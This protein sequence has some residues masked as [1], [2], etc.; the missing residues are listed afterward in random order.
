M[1]CSNRNLFVVDCGMYIFR[2]EVFVFVETLSLLCLRARWGWIFYG[3][4]EKRLSRWRN[5]RFFPKSGFMFW[6]FVRYRMQYF[7]SPDC[8]HQIV[9]FIYYTSLQL[10]T[11][12]VLHIRIFKGHFR[13]GFKDR[14]Q[15]PIF[16]V[17]SSIFGFFKNIT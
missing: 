15:F 10:C 8:F 12:R 17:N 3:R 5:G 9:C 13:P 1:L 4:Y 2:Y 11:K 6:H 16:W 7:Q 14:F